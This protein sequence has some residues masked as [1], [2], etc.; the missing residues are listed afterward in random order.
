VDLGI[1][2]R[3]EFFCAERIQGPVRQGLKLGLGAAIEGSRPVHAAHYLAAFLDSFAVGAMV[4]PSRDSWT[5]GPDPMALAVLARA[6]GLICLG[7]GMPALPGGPWP[8]PSDEWI[9]HHAQGAETIQQEHPDDGADWVAELLGL[10]IE[11]VSPVPLPELIQ[12]PGEELAARRIEIVSALVSEDAVA[13]ELATPLP[14]DP[15]SL[16]AMGEIRLEARAQCAMEAYGRAGLLVKEYVRFEA[17]LRAAPPGVLGEACVPFCQVALLPGTPA[18]LARGELQTTGWL[19]WDRAV[20][21]VPVTPVAV[22]LIRALDGNKGVEALSED[23]S[24]PGEQVSSIIEVLC[25]LG[26]IGL[27]R[28]LHSD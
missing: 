17:L 15:E 13:V 19:L 8:R 12:V 10:K 4:D 25:Q 20:A 26:A 11:R 27:P 14:Q 5:R 7:E 6:A 3:E 2:L 21:P 18:G 9:R 1:L 23:L 28:P 16:L 22:E 24:I